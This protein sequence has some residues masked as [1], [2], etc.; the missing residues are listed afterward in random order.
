MAE[1][2]QSEVGQKQKLHTVLEAVQDLLRPHGWGPQWTVEGEPRWG[3][4]ILAALHR[5]PR[6]GPEVL[7]A[8]AHHSPVLL[9]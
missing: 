7:P 5:Q 9:R 8:R 2:T 6:P 3:R 4:G 1:V